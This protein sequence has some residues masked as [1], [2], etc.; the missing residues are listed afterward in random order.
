M[1]EN[2]YEYLY[3]AEKRYFS[4][5][6]LTTANEKTYLWNQPS[7]FNFA[8]KIALQLVNKKSDLNIFYI[9]QQDSNDGGND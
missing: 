5:A 1:L 4:A 7:K 3:S 8:P 9:L 2:G 6:K